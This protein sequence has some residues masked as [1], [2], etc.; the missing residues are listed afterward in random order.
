M[1]PSFLPFTLPSINQHFYPAI[2]ALFLP[3]FLAILPSTLP[4]TFPSFMFPSF[5]SLF[6]TPFL[7]Y[8][9]SLSGPLGPGAAPTVA[10]KSGGGIHNATGSGRWVIEWA[11]DGVGSNSGGKEKE[12][13]GEQTLKLGVDSQL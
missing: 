3:L 8:P 11:K 12:S 13:E 6:L 4:F 5:F 9:L 2:L 1:F 7:P 10:A